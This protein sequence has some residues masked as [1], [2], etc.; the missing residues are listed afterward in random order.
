MRS[1][2]S[3]QVEFSFV[4]RAE[5]GKMALLAD[6]LGAEMHMTKDQTTKSQNITFSWRSRALDHQIA[7]LIASLAVERGWTVQRAGEEVSTLLTRCGF[8]LQSEVDPE[9]AFNNREARSANEK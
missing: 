1:E 7:A 5:I 2:I 8:E 6:A 9:K 3:T 4:S